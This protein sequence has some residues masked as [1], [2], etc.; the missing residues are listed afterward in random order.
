MISA[1]VTSLL[2]IETSCWQIGPSASEGDRKTAVDDPDFLDVGGDE[3]WQKPVQRHDERR[4]LA[5]L[6]DVARNPALEQID[7]DR[8]DRQAPG[9]NAAGRHP[10]PRAFPP[11]AR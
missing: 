11:D 7:E 3:R 4:G 9:R 6:D 2:S 10:D 8:R 1:S 5:I